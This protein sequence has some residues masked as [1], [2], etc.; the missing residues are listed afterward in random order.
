MV[1]ARDRS[2]TR[3]N[4]TDKVPS[5]DGTEI[6]FEGLGDGEAV[7]LIRGAPP[8]RAAHASLAELPAADFTVLNYDRRGRGESGDTLPSAAERVIED[9]GA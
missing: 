1:G 9:R 2:S 6:A 3:R 7:I 8:S 4:R 5:G